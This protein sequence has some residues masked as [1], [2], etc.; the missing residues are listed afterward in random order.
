MEKIIYIIT[1]R[2]AES[3]DQFKESL[4]NGFTKEINHLVDYLQ[5]N[6]VDS[7]VKEASLTR[8]G[9]E[10]EGQLPSKPVADGIVAVWVKSVSFNEKLEA[11][12]GSYTNTAYGYLVTESE[13]LENES[14][15]Y[16]PVRRTPG[17]DQVAFLKKPSNQE[18]DE[19]LY[20]W[21]SLHTQVAIDTQSTVRYIQNV[22]VRALT[23]D[24]PHYSAIVEEGFSEESAMFD[25]MVFYDAQGKKDRMLK[26]N[27]LMMESCSRF[28]DF[29]DDPTDLIAMSQYLVKK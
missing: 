18:Y 21:Q 5:I 7:G 16:S 1:K 11:T 23:K 25:P 20:N 12:L 3:G 14:Q 6:T 8:V 22:I 19:W 2:N 10:A 27:K 9:Q 13:P 15:A 28:I 17:F 24:A 29:Q 26:N 4:I